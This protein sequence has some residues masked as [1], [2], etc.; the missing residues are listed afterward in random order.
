VT[1]APAATGLSLPPAVARELLAHARRELPNEACGLLGGDAATGTV[2]A[3]HPASNELASPLRFSVDG[4]DLVRI[5]FAMEAAGQELVAIFHSHPAG[6]AEPSPSDI[7]E[8]RYP[9]ALHLLTGRDGRL[10]AWRIRAGSATEVPL[11]VA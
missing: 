8:A 7:R 11:T 4:Q 6:S 9:A 1:S 2:Q 3:F 5:T 10:R